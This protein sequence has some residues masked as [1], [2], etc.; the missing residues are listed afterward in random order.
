MGGEGEEEGEGEGEEGWGEEE[1]VIR[2][3]GE[4]IK[5]MFF[6]REMCRV[7]VWVW[8]SDGDDDLESCLPRDRREICIKGFLSSVPRFRTVGC[9]LGAKCHRLL[10]RTC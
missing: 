1:R 10:N 4:R 5:P 6:A 7:C 3:H 9:R 2:S 8:G